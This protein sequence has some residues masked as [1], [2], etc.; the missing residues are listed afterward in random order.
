MAEGTPQRIGDYE[1]L[2]ELGHGGMGRVYLVRNVIS[3]RIEAMKVLL[4]DLA[5][6]EEFVTRFMREIKLLASLD[7][8]NIA[9]LRTAFKADGQFVMIMEYVEGVTLA[10]KLE[11]GPFAVADAV[12]YIGQSLDALSYAHARQVIHRDIKPANM[13]LTPQGV[14]K[15][16]DFGLARSANEFGLTATGTTLG[17]LDYSS[18]E[19]VQSLPTDERSDLYSVGVSLY[20]MVTGQRMFSATS[21]YSLMQAQVAEVPRPPISIVPTLPAS[22]NEIIMMAVS[23]SPA[24]RFQSATAFRQALSQVPLSVEEQAG[25]AAAAAA[26]TTVVV[27]T[28]TAT[29]TPSAASQAVAEALPT[30]PPQNMPIA[31][32]LPPAKANP[33][34]ALLVVAVLVLLAL[35]TGGVVYKSRQHAALAKAATSEPAPAA[36]ASNAPA[37]PATPQST[38]TEGA[39]PD[40]APTAVPQTPPSS[41]TTTVARKAAAQSDDAATSAPSAANLQADQ[42]AAEAAAKRKKLLDDMET[43]ND[44][45]NTRASAVE[46]SLETLEQQM[47]NSGLGLRGD[48]VAARGNMRNDLSK[49][50]QALDGGDTDR[51]RHFLD[52]AHREVEK[53]EGFM[54]RR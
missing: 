11:R 10:D 27:G 42:Q 17:S 37:P 8:P 44:Q 40:A 16:M 25:S 4:P 23:K 20:Q 49:A 1:V 54:G 50:Q 19:Q 39:H 21:S 7:H 29:P 30:S 31:Y 3:D 2:R 24:Q 13:M 33:N 18:P 43:E 38:S 26:A 9:A 48:M 32:G 47:H 6:R 15:L 14:V 51:A 53:L 34:R 52:L 28:P 35:L 36:P 46:S 41:K 22:L 12:N 45:L 5:A